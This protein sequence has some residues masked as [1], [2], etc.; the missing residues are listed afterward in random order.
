MAHTPAKPAPPPAKAPARNEPPPAKPEGAAAEPDPPV[1]TVADE[2][3]ER[4]QQIA[5]MGVEAFKAE[6][7]Q[8]DEADKPKQVAGVSPTSVEA[9]SW[10]GSTRSTPEARAAQRRTAP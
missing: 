9:G 5:D 6:G 7:D 8:R 10:A 2:Q 3:R 4:S 1:K